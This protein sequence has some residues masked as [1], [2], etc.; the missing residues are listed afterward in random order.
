V[1][2]S[3]E[4]VTD[5]R[6]SNRKE[7]TIVRDKRGQTAEK[8]H[9]RRR[10]RTRQTGVKENDGWQRKKMTGERD[11]HRHRHSYSIFYVH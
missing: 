2:D 8:E 3:G 6:E 7:R 11:S 1:T 9:E 4:K 5:E 10:E